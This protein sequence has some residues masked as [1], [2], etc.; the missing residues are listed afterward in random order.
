MEPLPGFSGGDRWRLVT[1]VSSQARLCSL[2]AGAVPGL[3]D[4]LWA[5]VSLCVKCWAVTG[6]AHHPCLN[7]ESVSPVGVW[8]QCR[9]H[10]LKDPKNQVPEMKRGDSTGI[11]VPPSAPSRDA[12]RLETWKER[13]GEEP[14]EA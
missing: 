1:G 8:G 5:S 11:A 4:S 13:Q 2:S 10:R 14:A 7:S 3:T 6:S 9:G 12:V